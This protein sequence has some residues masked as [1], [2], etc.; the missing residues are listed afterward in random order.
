M[1]IFLSF[2]MTK[3]FSKSPKHEDYFEAV[4]VMIFVSS[5]SQW[6]LGITIRLNHQSN[7]QTTDLFYL[8]LT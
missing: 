8:S 1:R 2:Y 5:H 4:G 6:E 7:A 3:L